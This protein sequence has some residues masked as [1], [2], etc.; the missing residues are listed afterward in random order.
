MFV[1]FIEGEFGSAAILEANPIFKFL[2]QL[3]TIEAFKL[4]EGK[5]A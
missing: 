3:L 5:F 1:A 2:R 4:D